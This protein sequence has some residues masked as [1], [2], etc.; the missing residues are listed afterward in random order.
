MIPHDEPE[1]L[2][3]ALRTVDHLEESLLSGL[4][5]THHG[6]SVEL[7]FEHLRRGK[8]VPETAQV[9]IVMEAVETLH[10]TGG[11]SQTMLEHPERINWGL[12]EV[13]QVTAYPAAAGV[14]F[15]VAWEGEREIRVEAARARFRAS[16]T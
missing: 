10:L 8:P 15:L 16:P 7:R 11:L 2:N 6:Y 14:G 12:S 9:T 3:A 4:M 1:S 13:A 5:L